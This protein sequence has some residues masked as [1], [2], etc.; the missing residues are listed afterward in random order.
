[1]VFEVC[2]SRRFADMD[3]AMGA[4]WLAQKRDAEIRDLCSAKTDLRKVALKR[5][6]IRLARIGKAL[7]NYGAP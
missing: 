2:R 6:E 7:Y 1:M 5:R 3:D 4:W